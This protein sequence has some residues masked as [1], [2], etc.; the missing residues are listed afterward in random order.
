MGSTG[1]V[2]GVAWTVGTAVVTGGTVEA[3]ATS[4]EGPVKFLVVSIAT[5]L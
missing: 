1:A 2:L 5:P 3:T 4:S